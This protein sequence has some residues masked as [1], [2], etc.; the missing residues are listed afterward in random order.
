V[1]EERKA[2]EK[3]KLGTMLAKKEKKEQG[4]RESPA[5]PQ[6]MFK[7]KGRSRGTEKKKRRE[8]ENPRPK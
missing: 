3:K 6:R 4:S 2:E 7:D 8:E 5:S 1:G